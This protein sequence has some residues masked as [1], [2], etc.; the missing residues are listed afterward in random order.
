[1]ISVM[2]VFIFLVMVTLDPSGYLLKLKKTLP[3]AEVDF[4]TIYSKM[5]TETN[6]QLRTFQRLKD[7]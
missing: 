1:M 5:A 6:L 7:F 4:L 3:K 2:Q